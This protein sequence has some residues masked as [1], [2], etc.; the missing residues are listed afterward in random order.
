MRSFRLLGFWRIFWEGSA[1]YCSPSG[2][3]VCTPFCKEAMLNAERP[4]V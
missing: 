2:S 4:K 3:L 1:L